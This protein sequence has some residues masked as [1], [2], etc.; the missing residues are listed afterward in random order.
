[1]KINHIALWVSDLEIMKAFYLKYFN[2]TSN[3]K[4]VNPAR[5]Y[6]SYSLSFD[7]QSARLELMHKPSIENYAGEK[8][9]QTGLAHIA[10][11]VGSKER[12]DELTEILRNDRFII[13]GEPRMT[14]DG[15]YES[16][17]LDPEGNRVE[18]TI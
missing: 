8:G 16:I 7:D 15:C 11:S 14:G 6:S 12:A 10:I 18:I 5:Q 2:M 4:Y 13:A 9:M 17:V 3:K 1:M